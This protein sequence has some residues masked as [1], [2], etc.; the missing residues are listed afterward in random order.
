MENTSKVLLFSVAIL[1]S[2]I[3][4]TAGIKIIGSVSSTTKTVDEFGKSLSN[5]LE[6]ATY[7]FSGHKIIRCSDQNVNNPN[8]LYYTEFATK[9]HLDY[10][11]EYTVS[12]DYEIMENPNNKKLVVV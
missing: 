3:L 4:V 5:S 11:Y 1:I 7:I 12:F 6:D 9:V 10:D 2:I 8:N